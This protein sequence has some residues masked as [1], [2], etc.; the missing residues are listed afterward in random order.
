[1]TDRVSKAV[2]RHLFQKY[3]E[4]PSVVYAINRVTDL[5]KSDPVEISNYMMEK[6]WVREVWVHQNNIVTCRITVHGIEEINPSFIQT[7]VKNLVTELIHGGGQ[8]SLA[9]IFQHKIQEYAI[10]LDI[11]Y[12]LEKLGLITISPVKGVIHI[13]LTEAGW[14]YSEKQG[15][16][17]LTL[18]AVA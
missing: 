9:E 1:M 17:L 12:Q 4:A 7:K 10:A 18:M 3:L 2:L 11:V 13:E 16:S 6:N 15:K 5:S 8:K 14:K